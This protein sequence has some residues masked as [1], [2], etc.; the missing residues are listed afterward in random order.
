MSPVFEPPLILAAD[1]SG[2]EDTKYRK[3]RLAG[4]L[5]QF[6]LECPQFDG[7]LLFQN[8]KNL[9]EVDEICFRWI[10]VFG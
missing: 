1:F 2:I 4:S 9:T 10:K 5:C 7:A 6:W 3:R 8:K